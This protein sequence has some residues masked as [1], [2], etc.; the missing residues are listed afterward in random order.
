M[1]LNGE[2]MK[3]KENLIMSVFLDKIKDFIQ[4]GVMDPSFIHDTE[5]W[6]NFVAKTWDE[7]KHKM[8]N[9]QIAELLHNIYD[10]CKQKIDSKK[11]T[12]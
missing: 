3:A 7:M 5:K 12:A 1:G 4:N 11:E 9:Q 8:D 6:G 2:E 10:I